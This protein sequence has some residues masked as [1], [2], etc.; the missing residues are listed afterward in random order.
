MLGRRRRPGAS[1]CR[2]RLSRIAVAPVGELEE[3]ARIV[4]EL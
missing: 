4:V 3:V 1:Y 2:R